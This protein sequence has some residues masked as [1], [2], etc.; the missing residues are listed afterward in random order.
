MVIYDKFGSIVLDIDVEDDSYRYRAIMNGTQVVLYYSL[1]EHVEV[2]VG[3]YIEYQGVKYTLWRPENFKKHGTRNFEYTVEFGGDEEALKK[4]KIKDLS[5]TPNKLIFSYTA[6]PRQLLQLIVDNLNLREGGWKVGKCIEGVEKLYSFNN[7]YIFDALNRNAGDLKTEWNIANKTIDLCKVEYFKDDPL[8]LSYGKGN[9]FL[10]GTGRANTGDKQ[11]IVILYVQGGERNIDASKYGSTTLLLPKDQEIEYEG[12]KYHTSKDG[13]FLYRS[14]RDTTAGQEDGYDGSHIYPSRVGTI[15][16]V[17]VADA[18]KNFYDIIDTSIP[19]ALDYAQYRIAGQRATIKFESGR[20]AGREFDLEQTDE[21]LTG[22][23]HAERRFKIVPAELDGQVMPNETFRPAVGDKYAIFGIALPDAYI[24]DNVTKTGASW[25]MLREAV[26]YLYENEDEQFSFTGELKGSWAKKRWLEIGGKILPG[27]YVLFSDTQYQPEGVL[28]RITGVRDYINN[29]H[30]P[31]IELS[32]VPVAPSK[33]SELG[34]IESNEVIVEEKHKESLSFT[35]RRYLDMVETGKMLEKAIEGFS[36]SINPVTV[37]TMQ[38]R[39]GAEQLQFRFVNNKTTPSEIIPNFRMNNTT[40]VFSAPASILQHMSLGITKVSPT[41]SPNEYK[42]WDISAY[43]SPYLGDDKSPY[44]LYAKC[45]KSGTTGIFEL[46]KEPH[47]MEEGSFYYFLV[48]TLGTE[49]E[50]VRSFTTCYGFTEILP[51]RMV[52]NLIT[53][54]DGKTYFNLVEGV[55]GGKIHFDSGTTGYENIKDKPDL[56][57]YGTKDLLNAIQSDLQNQIDDKIETYY[58]TSNPWNS[59]PSETEPAHVGDLW[60]NTSTKILQRYVGPSS[61]TWSRIEDADAIAAA[62]A[63]SM[64]QDTA[65]GKRRVFLST[66]YPPYDAGDQWIDGYGSSSGTMRICVRS[67]QSGSYVSSDWQITSADGNTQASIDR[68]IFT[69]AGFMTFGGSAGM[70]GDGDIRIWSGGTNANNATFQVTAAGEVMAKKAIKLQ[71][72][73]AGITGEGTADTSVR[74]WAGN[75]TPASA[76]FRVYQN[77]NA[78]IGGLRMENGG[79]FSDNQYSGLSNS[80]FFLYS[81][82]GSAFL[83]FSATGK[84]AGIGLNTLPASTGTAALLRLENT[85]SEPY[86]T[87]YGAVITVSGGSKNIALLTKGDI[88]VDGTVQANV[89]VAKS[90]KNRMLI[91]MDG[92]VRIDN[93]D[94]WFVFAKGICVG[95]RKMREYDSNADE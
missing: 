25:D 74:F 5:I 89:Y 46:S 67:R 48:G 94:T 26:R 29:P 95:A 9:G 66:P 31:E 77:G 70:V 86:S 55:I 54:T 42:F 53:S 23:V 52:I 71:N 75:A 62:E 27:G 90:V 6:T 28:I 92:A 93:S 45:S 69:A 34:K 50:N 82:G 72:Q 40:K 17:I 3:S 44:Y 58:G 11:P 81:N 43:T 4:Y 41:H 7:E 39:L 51:G 1:T 49:W 30:S 88:Q 24:C 32:N 14:D 79:L 60:Y 13:T 56:S 73:Q 19:D 35:M 20:L 78:F 64:A 22:Y 8:P 84:W 10:P 16:E 38:I 61:N 33:S 2:P 57:I 65:D 91:G 80:K 36:A 15:S 12:R 76:P 59:W 47:K 68:G 21:E 87:K 37:S 18:E 83:G 85:N 63:A